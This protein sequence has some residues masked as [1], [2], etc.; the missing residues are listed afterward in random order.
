MREFLK[1]SS[2]TVILKDCSKEAT[3]HLRKMDEKFHKSLTAGLVIVVFFPSI[4]IQTFAAISRSLDDSKK[5]FNR[6][7]QSKAF[8]FAG[9]ATN[10]NIT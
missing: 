9:S 7:S 3:V 5:T 10:D 2:T 1:T 8:D 6:F 4:W